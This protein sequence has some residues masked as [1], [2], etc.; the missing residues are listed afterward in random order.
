M[1]L[2]TL[3]MNESGDKS[4]CRI[5]NGIVA[6]TS[7]Y[8]RG[9]GTL[10]I[11]ILKVPRNALNRLVNQSHPTKSQVYLPLDMRAKFVESVYYDICRLLC[12]SFVVIARKRL[13]SQFR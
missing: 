9:G 3:G 4:N 7:I 5:N 1:S 8:N 2:S 11:R 12:S 13:Q 10:N 6:C